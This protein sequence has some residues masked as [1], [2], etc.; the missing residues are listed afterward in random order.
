M[1]CLAFQKGLL[2]ISREP[3][4]RRFQ[5][6]F[7]IDG[8]AIPEQGS[9]FRDVCLGVADIAGTKVP[10]DG[11][12]MTCPCVNLGDEGANVSE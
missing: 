3:L 12:N 5:T 10:I 7:H 1:Y 8:R 4:D 11:L 2:L 9:S 6:L